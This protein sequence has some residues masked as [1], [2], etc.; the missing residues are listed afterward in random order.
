MHVCYDEFM[1]FGEYL[2]QALEQ[3]GLSQRAFALEVG[4][5]QQAIN[6]IVKGIRIPPLGRLQGWADTLKGH[7]DRGMFMELAWLEHS[8]PGI[9]KAL[10]DA[11]AE[12]KRLKS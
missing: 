4:Y 7:I 9:R 1:R 12:I 11:R 5:P 10:E 8:P 6:G 3:K 2:G